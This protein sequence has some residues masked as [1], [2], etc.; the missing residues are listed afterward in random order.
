MVYLCFFSAV[1]VMS[2]NVEMDLLGSLSDSF[3]SNTLALV[4]AT[5]ETATPEGNANTG[6]TASFVAAS[7]GSGN[8]NQVGI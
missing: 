7:P 3:P 2:S 8:F 4:P 5:A 6:S 1:P